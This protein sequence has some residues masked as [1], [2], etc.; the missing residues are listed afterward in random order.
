M[1]IKTYLSEIQIYDKYLIHEILYCFTSLTEEITAFIQLGSTKTLSLI[2][3]SWK[4]DE[5]KFIT[6]LVFTR[7]PKTKP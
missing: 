6:Y 1:M 3:M 4:H 5:Y 7:S 2:L